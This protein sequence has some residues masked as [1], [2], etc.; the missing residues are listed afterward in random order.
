MPPAVAAVAEG[1]PLPLVP[2]RTPK[3]D[4][5]TWTRGP[6]SSR[7]AG[8]SGCVTT[9]SRCSSTGASTPHR[10]RACGTCSA[11][12]P[13]RPPTRAQYPASFA[14]RSQSFDPAA[15]ARLARD[16]GAGEV[17]LTIRHHDGF[18]LWPAATSTPGPP[19]HPSPSVPTS[20]RPT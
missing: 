6:G 4:R 10:R 14:T 11:R 20:S 19:P 5:G 15:W 16:L 13:S 9:S 1:D 7:T 8:S 12:R 3:L 18:A 2:L 17:V